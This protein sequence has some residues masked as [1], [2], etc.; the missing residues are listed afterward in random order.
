MRDADLKALTGLCAKCGTCRTVCTL[1]PE[2]K[3]G[4]AVARG[5]LALIEAAVVGEDDDWDG[6]QEALAATGHQ[7]D[8]RNVTGV[9]SVK[10]IPIDPRTGLLRGGVSPTG[11]SYVMA[12]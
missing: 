3:A 8:I 5:K 9:G 10:A 6:V 11:D 12:W 7:L 2:R 1:Y 4:L